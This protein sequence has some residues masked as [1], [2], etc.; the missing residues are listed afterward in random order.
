M[1]NE[2]VVLVKLFIFVYVRARAC[3]LGPESEGAM[4]I[5]IC[6]KTQQEDARHDIQNTEGSLKLRLC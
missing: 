3:L 2:V 4:S 6:T 5:Q 1:A